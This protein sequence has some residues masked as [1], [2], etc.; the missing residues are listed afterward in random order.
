M[1]LALRSMPPSAVTPAPESRSAPCNASTGRIPN[2]HCRTELRLARTTQD[3]AEARLPNGSIPYVAIIDGWLRDETGC[4][5]EAAVTPR[6][7][8]PR[9]SVGLGGHRLSTPVSTIG[10]AGGSSVDEI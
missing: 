10:S 6:I 1:G 2:S 7:G 3:T 4:P 9:D 8:D 5:E